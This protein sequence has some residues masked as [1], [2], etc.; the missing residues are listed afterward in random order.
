MRTNAGYEIID[1]IH[2][3]NV[4]FVLG[5]RKGTQGTQFVTWRCYAG[6]EYHFGH[7][8]ENYI[9]ALIDLHER[10]QDEIIFVISRLKETEEL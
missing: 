7:Y 5:E 10:A 9:E 1:A 4:E 2:L 3:P 8:I 6:K